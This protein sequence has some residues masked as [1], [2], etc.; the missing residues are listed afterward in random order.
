GRRALA[1]EWRGAAAAVAVLDPARGGPPRR[2]QPRHAA[3]LGEGRREAR[4][5]LPCEVTARGLVDL[6]QDAHAESPDAA[7]LSVHAGVAADRYDHERR[8]QRSGHERVGRHR[9]RRA[10]RARREHDD[11][12]REPA[13]R[14]AEDAVVERPR[15]QRGAP[16][17]LTLIRSFAF[18]PSTSYSAMQLSA[19]CFQRS[20]WPE[21]SAPNSA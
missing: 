17:P 12:G 4:D 14:P 11:A 10:A 9:V 13:E 15:H 18:H 8:T 6:V 1:S 5:R 19:N 21:A 2:G 7:E 3:E 20:Y 16:I